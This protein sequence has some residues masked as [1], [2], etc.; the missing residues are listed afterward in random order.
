MGF[1]DVRRK[2]HVAALPRGGSR[3]IL[4]LRKI[5]NVL[6]KTKNHQQI[7]PQIPPAGLEPVEWRDEVEK[8]CIARTNIAFG[9]VATQSTDKTSTGTLLL[10]E[11]GYKNVIALSF[12]AV[13]LFECVLAASS[14]SFQDPKP[15]ADAPPHQC[16]CT[17]VDVKDQ[18]SSCAGAGPPV[19]G[20]KRQHSRGGV[21]GSEPK[22]QRSNDRRHDEDPY[23]NGNDDGHDDSD[24]GSD[25]NDAAQKPKRNGPPKKK[26]DCPFHKFCPGR[27][28]ECERLILTTW[29]RV[30]QHL[31]R[32][33][34]LKGSYCACCRI[35]FQK[36]EEALRDEHIRRR[37]CQE[38]TAKETGLLLPSE[39]NNLKKLGRVSDED[40]WMVAWDRLFLGEPRPESAR[41]ET[42][43]DI[44]RR[45]AP[46]V[47]ARVPELA[48]ISDARM[49]EIV[50][51]L[52]PRDSAPT[53]DP[54][55][56]APT[57]ALASNPAAMA[58]TPIMHHTKAEVGGHGQPSSGQAM[59]APV[60]PY[61]LAQAHV[62]SS[63]GYGSS[64]PDMTAGQSIPA[65]P[66]EFLLYPEGS[67]GQQNPFNQL[68]NHGSM[69]A[70]P[71]PMHDMLGNPIYWGGFSNAG[72]GV[73]PGDDENGDE[74]QLNHI[75]SF[76]NSSGF[77]FNFPGSGSEY[78]G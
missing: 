11:D 26:L 29:D 31:K 41:F 20:H 75:S 27:F 1:S 28:T 65:L 49:T 44:R 7:P 46:S 60:I 48:G 18:V 17:D 32:V 61:P 77:P 3:P 13:Q 59:N 53:S 30:F 71:G 50:D 19:H 12:T 62:N 42:E 66:G 24:G 34:L 35:I 25:E 68:G 39:Y 14:H 23:S 8:K 36:G 69:Q 6:G 2:P 56:L 57:P 16:D 15:P 67:A 55:Q 4:L 43:L 58:L 10:D 38:A 76:D 51:A 73:G 63:V 74:D 33:H 45:K 52:F 54:T 5:F 64:G 9:D 40:K 72:M 22:K 47:L 37:E 21:G 78:M 70:L